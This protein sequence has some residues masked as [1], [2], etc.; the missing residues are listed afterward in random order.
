MCFSTQKDKDKRTLETRFDAKCKYDDA[1]LPELFIGFAFPETPVIADKAPNEIQL[2]TWGLL[3]S[4]AKDRTIQSNT[5]N[6]KIET[7]HEKP[8]FKNSISKRCL[9]LIDGFYEWQWLDAKG[10]RKQKYFIS[11]PEKEP[12]A[13]AGIWNSWVD[14]ATGEIVDTYS[15]VTTAA[16]LLMEEIHNTKKRMPVVLTK[17]NEGDWLNGRTVSDFLVCD[18]PLL[19][20]KV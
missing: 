1:A 19:A 9:V 7:L 18:V 15:I 12:F 5:L 11:V 4:W 17:E 20:T 13:L 10:K 8:S 2:F 3:P 6:A 16:N 14:R